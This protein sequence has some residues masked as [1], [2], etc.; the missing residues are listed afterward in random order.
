[1]QKSGTDHD[2]VIVGAGPTGTL[3]AIELGRRG[4]NVRVVERRRGRLRHPRASGVQ[5]RTMELFRQLDLGDEIRRAGGLP[6]SDW[7]RFVYQT[8]LNQ[9]PLGIFDMMLNSR[10]VE[11]ALDHSPEMHAWCAQDSLEDVLRNRLRTLATVTVDHG[12]R[13]TAVTQN[14]DSVQ[15]SLVDEATGAEEVVS[16]RYLVG[17][18]GGRSVVRS[19]AGIASQESPV[20]SHQVNVCFEADLTEY[21]GDEIGILH[22]I[23]NPDTQGGV[24]TYDGARHWV[25]S[26][27]YDPEVLG[28]DHFTPE[29]CTNVIRSAVGVL[30]LDI[31]IMGTFFWQIDSAL[32]DTFGRGRVFL[33]G[34]A[35]HRFPPA[36]GFGMN[37]G[38]QDAQNLA[39]KLH[40]VLRGTASE[41]LLATYD[42]ERRAAAVSNADLALFNA[43]KSA[44]VGW[45]LTDPA[46][47]ADIE[48]PQGEGTRRRIAD[49]IPGQEAQ[50]WSYGQQFGRIYESAAVI[51]DGTP[52]QEPS[53]TDYRPSA[54]PGAHAPHVRLSDPAGRELSTIDLLHSRFVVLATP[55]GYQ[56]A[57]AARET[58]R[59]HG[60]LIDSFI[61][62]AQGDYIDLDGNWTDRYGLSDTG[63]VLVRP[64]GHVAFRAHALD[65]DQDA[66]TV[67]DGVFSRLLGARPADTLVTG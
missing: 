37:S 60:I 58:A 48:L 28:R 13:A 23:V 55:A 2:V 25:Y 49:A 44:E 20:L 59:R 54:R 63:A 5:A 1:M 11:E 33:V 26:W 38:L 7:S 6:S 3:L 64:D 61:I 24:I 4:I 30:D 67:L 9:P 56:W 40:E 36:G 32:A 27:E 53:V 47:I 12:V 22:W 65:P 29:H 21:I 19:A 18:D 50:Y 66:A 39:W 31:R 57:T 46:T 34:D 42:T 41:E 35:A 16:A 14:T 8:R 45:I 17:A 52:P 43:R 10:R 51:P 62:G 15:L